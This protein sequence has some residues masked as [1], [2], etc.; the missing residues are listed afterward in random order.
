MSTQ[1]ALDVTASSLKV[2]GKVVKSLSG[3]GCGEY[4]RKRG[5]WDLDHTSRREVLTRVGN[6]GTKLMVNKFR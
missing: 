4:S 5:G 1:K 3:S 2:I 6:A